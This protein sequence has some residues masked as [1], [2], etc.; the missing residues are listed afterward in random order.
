MKQKITAFIVIASVLVAV[1]VSLMALNQFYT[2]KTKLNFYVFS[3]SQGYQGSLEQIA[4]I[5]QIAQTNQ[6]DFVFHCGDLTPFGQENQ[7][8]AVLSAL[9]R[10]PVPVHV[11]P[12]NHDI[13][14]GGTQRYLR[15]FG[16]ATYSFDVWRAHFTVLNTS[17]GNMSESQFQWLHDDL[18]GSESEYKFVFT[19]IPPFDPRP[20]EDHALTNS[21]TAARL[22]SLFEEF[23][24]NTVFAGHI[25]MYNESVRNGVRYVITGGAGASLYATPEN[26]GIYHFVNVTLTDSQL[27]IEPVILES[28]ALPRDKVVIRGQSDDMTLTIDDLSALPTIEGFSS[29]QNQYGNWGGQGIYRGVLFSDLVELVGGMHENDTL[30]VTSFDGYGQVFCYSNVYPNSTWYTAQGDMVL[31]YQMNNT[32]VPDWDDGLR[33]VMIPEDGAFSNDDCLFTSALGTGC[34]AYLSAGARWVRYVSIIEVVPG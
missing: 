4:Q 31:A 24:V 28:P 19:H 13:R 11:T 29:F 25:H 18:A 33:V 23:K 17:G 30:N 21:T 10:F 8:S 34:Y 6:P 27:I 5:A 2:V 22:M 15:Y 3:D 32:L 12:G 7:Y 1:P 9:S 14:Q 16:A 20:G 26:G